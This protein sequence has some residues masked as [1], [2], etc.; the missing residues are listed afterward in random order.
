MF[1]LFSFIISLYLISLFFISTYLSPCYNSHPYLAST[2]PHSHLQSLAS[3]FKSSSITTTN[4][5]SILIQQSFVSGDEFI[6]NN[7]QPI[8]GSPHVCVTSCATSVSVS[9]VRTAR[10]ATSCSVIAGI[11]TAL[12]MWPCCGVIVS[13]RVIV[14]FI[15]SVI[16]IFVAIIFCSASIIVPS[17]L[18]TISI[19]FIP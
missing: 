16:I 13:V 3:L 6:S 2:S 12:A 10:G 19:S 4:D 5:T 11:R 18:S 14:S 8:S 1:W 7:F 9:I 17:I 15:E